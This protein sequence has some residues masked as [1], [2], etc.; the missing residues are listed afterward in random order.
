MHPSRQ[1]V[2]T[3][4][5]TEPA[6]YINKFEITGSNIGSGKI[7]SEV[8]PNRIFESQLTGPSHISGPA[9]SCRFRL[10][11]LL[12]LLAKLRLRN[13]ARLIACRVMEAGHSSGARVMGIVCLLAADE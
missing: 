11:R 1:D 6:G 7:I 9:S 12:L 5:G 3:I 4:A 2:C 13:H 8:R 10:D